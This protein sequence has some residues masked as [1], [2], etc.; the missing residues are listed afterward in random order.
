MKTRAGA[1]EPAEEPFDLVSSLV[2]LAVVFPWVAA[3]ALGWDDRCVAESEGELPCFGPFVG[4]VC[5]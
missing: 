4:A 1:F 2:C 5:Y 3:V